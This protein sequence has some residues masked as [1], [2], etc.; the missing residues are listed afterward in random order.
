MFVSVD[1]E[2]IFYFT[3][4]IDMGRDSDTL[5]DGRSG[6]RVPVEGRFSELNPLAYT[7]GCGTG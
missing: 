3:T 1:L 7:A 5:R 2:T 6:D 4:G